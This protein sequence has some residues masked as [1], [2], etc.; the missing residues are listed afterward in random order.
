MRK[1]QFIFESQDL[2]RKICGINDNGVR[3]LEKQL[4][5]GLIPRGNGFQVEGN[6]QKVDFALDFFKLLETNYRDRPDR[7]LTDSFDFSYLLKQATR[8][9]KKDDRSNEPF[10]PTEKIL[11]TY[12]GKHLYPRTKNQDKYIQSF[13]NNLITFGVGPAGTGKT[14]LSVATACRFLQNG[15]I[16]RIVL[17]RPAVEAGEN[18][19]FLPGD[20]NQKVDPYLRPVYDALNECI[21]FEKTQEYIALTKIE[22][23]PV[24]FMRGRT[25]SNSFIILDEAQNCTLSQLKMIMT[26][27]GRNSRMCISGDVT[28]IDLEHGRSGFDRVV[29]L[30]RNTEG[31]GLVFF[32]KED[33][34]RH[35]LV[36]TIVRKFEEL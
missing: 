16:D 22:I 5:I 10:K 3:V 19:G 9:R 8:E 24:A 6:S 14:F 11:T 30:F 33:I 34:T 31:I 18:L 12:R 20:L 13:L 2:Y 36:E 17:T 35:P 4:E 29:N 23:A 25:L 28:Q 26:R 15:V 21:G 7:D 32:G 1:E 27:L